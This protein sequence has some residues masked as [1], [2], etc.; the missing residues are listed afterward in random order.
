MPFEATRPELVW[1]GKYDEQ[2]RRRVVDRVTLPFRVVERLGG[3][4]AG[5]FEDG[6]RNQLIWGDNQRVMSSLLDRHAGQVDLI[7][8]DPP[9]ASGGDFVM[10]V[11]IG[12]GSPAGETSGASSFE[13]TLYRDSWQGGLGTYLAML[14]DRLTLMRELLRDTGSL[15]IHV[16]AIAGHYV[17]V[18]ADEIFGAGSFQREIIWRIGWVSGFKSAARNWIRNHDTI[19]FYVKSPGSFTFN[20]TYVPY[21]P[22]YRRRGGGEPTGKGYPI[23]DVWNASP[24]EQELKGEDSLDSIQIKSF[25]NEKTGYA[26]QKN[27]SVLRRII[28]ASSNPGDLVADFF[29]GSGTTQAVAE[30]TGRRWIGADLGRSAIH[31]TRKRL[32]DIPGCRPFDLLDLGPHERTHWQMATFGGNTDD[33]MAAMLRLYGAAPLA[34]STHLHG[35]MGEAAVHIGAADVP[36]SADEIALC[37]EECALV[38]AK[39]L[40]ILGWDWQPGV[41]D[42]A[43]AD[44]AA[45]GVDLLLRQIPRELMEDQAVARGDITFF[46]LARLDLQLRPTRRRHEVV[47]TLRHFDLPHPDLLS[48]TVREKIARW[49]DHVDSWAVDWTF[50]GDTFEPGWVTYRTRKARSLRWESDPHVFDGPGEYTVMVKVVDIFGN[51]TAWVRPVTIA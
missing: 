31:I 35:R 18:V 51:D 46:E 13:T 38:G 19:L 40:H 20:K 42:P 10:T 30:K 16:D 9:F 43:A 2:G 1:P 47:V 49:S 12:D 27:E 37:L 22:G 11:P 26:T 48:G 17:K 21:P 7:Y 14:A 8:L 39:E 24:A 6:W 3:E 5:A 23:D 32:L 34:G 44:A 33:Y 15:Y 25:S 41:Q 50:T 45:R 4:P 29:C 36:V 28:E